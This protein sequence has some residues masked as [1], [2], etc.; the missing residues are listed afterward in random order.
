[1]N[2]IGHI[3]ASIYLNLQILW[4]LQNT[5]SYIFQIT[6]TILSDQENSTTMVPFIINL[7]RM[8]AVA[9]LY[10]LSFHLEKGNN[11]ISPYKMCAKM[12]IYL[13]SIN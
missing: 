7:T 6:N 11:Y 3:G 8:P 2:H 1:M 5:T 12:S 9:I 10:S 4:Q 13:H